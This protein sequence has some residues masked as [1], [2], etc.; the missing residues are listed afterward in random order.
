MFSVAAFNT[1]SGHF[2]PMRLHFAINSGQLESVER[3]IE[4]G[5]D[6]NFAA[7]S[8]G[9]TPLVLSVLSQ[10][11]DMATALVSAGADVRVAEKTSWRRRPVQL[12]AGAGHRCLVA[13]MLHLAP[14]EVSQLCTFSLVQAMKSLQEPLG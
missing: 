9:E 12:A 1:V 6:V 2:A 5:V 4:S 10:R 8:N 11:V 7:P 13:D 3:L 14:D